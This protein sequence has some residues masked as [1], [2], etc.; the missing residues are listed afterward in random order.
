MV[1]DA[2]ERWMRERMSAALGLAPRP[3]VVH[4]SG[5]F[6]S[7][8]PVSALATAAVATAAVAAAEL[9]ET[10]GRP[11]RT[12]HVD[13][14]L[15]DR[16]FAAAVQ[17]VG[18][19]PP[20]L[21]DPIAGAYPAQDGWIR[22]HTNAAHHR[23]AALGVLGLGTE[24]TRDAVAA[25]VAGWAVTELE[26]AILAG[27]GCAA[28]LRTP[29]E[30][31]QHPQG[32]AVAAEPLVDRR[33]TGRWAGSSTWQPSSD[34]PL[35]G[36]RVLDLTRVL[37]GPAATRL[38]AGL[39]A[40]VL[41]LD[42]PD[43]EEPALEPEMTLGKRCAR[44]DLRGAGGR[45]RFDELLESADVLVHGYRPG[46]LDRLG[47]DEA[48]RDER[49]VGLVELSLD[50]YGHTGPWA[51]RRGFDSLVQMSSGI[52]AA[53]IVDGTSAEPTPLPTQALD[54]ATGW[55]MAAAVLAGLTGRLRDGTGMRARLS[56]ARTAVELEE[57]RR[58][59]ADAASDA[60]SAAVPGEVSPSTPASTRWDTPPST[61][62]D[63]PWGAAE[64]LAPPFAVDGVA[65]GWDRG[66]RP[67]GSD[68]ARW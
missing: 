22:L 18:W 53:G 16:W 4:G 51:G 12:V 21:W 14:G 50:A 17:P 54:Q 60:A 36:L 63:T 6:R 30:W 39:G 19:E 8:Y 43:W 33:T 52:A 55:L 47:W 32:A 15:A 26:S 1:A 20:P 5:T 41:R 25:A 23:R 2:P 38:L 62:L 7:A 37:A 28:E 24:T 44:I 49:R 3:V 10:L 58:A 35:A 34:R 64:L 65:L 67:L 46:A 57:A 66:P 31:A 11:P 56:L 42:P 45:E 9:S 13:R 68:P 27:G 48:A 59:A 40:E 61:R 29:A